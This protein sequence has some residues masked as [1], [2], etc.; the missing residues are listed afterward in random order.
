MTQP[1]AQDSERSSSKEA[2]SRPK[3][4]NLRYRRPPFVGGPNRFGLPVS[5]SEERVG[6]YQQG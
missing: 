5:V 4:S 2:A 6:L 1:I 3:G